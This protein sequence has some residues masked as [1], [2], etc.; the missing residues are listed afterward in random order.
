M[1]LGK[2]L[3][4]LALSARCAGGGPSLVV[5]PASLVEN[6]RREA[7]RFA[8]HL[9]SSSTAATAASGAGRGS[10]GWDL[11]IT[12]YGTLARDR[13]LFASVEFACVVGDEAQHVKNRLSQ[14]ARALRSLARPGRFLLTGTP[15]ENS[16]DDLRSLFDFILP[17]YLE[18]SRRRARRG[19]GLVRR[20]A[21]GQD[22]PYI[23]RRT[24]GAVAPELPARIEQVV[25]CALEP[26]QAAL[27]RVVPGEVGARAVRPGGLRRGRGR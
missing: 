1:G 11:V 16:L 21:A 14:N 27:Y 23:L 8:P 9:A 15:V 5:C 4:A 18:R 13:E 17:G 6:W 22:G 19:A 3:Q 2:T 20:A 24:K 26:G 7:A 10:P 12:S 25:W